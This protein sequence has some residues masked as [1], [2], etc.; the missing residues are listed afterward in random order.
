MLKL[1]RHPG[2]LGLSMA[3]RVLYPAIP[4]SY[5]GNVVFRYLTQNF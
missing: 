1:A 2:Y 3:R 5:T 4:M